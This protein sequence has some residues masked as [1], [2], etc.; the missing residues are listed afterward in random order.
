MDLS[1]YLLQYLRTALWSTTDDDGNPLDR[2]YDI[3]DF[4][5]DS[6]KVAQSELD[7]FLDLALPLIPEDSPFTWEDLTHDFWL[8]RNR[9]GA[10]FWDGE[11]PEPLSTQLT[12][13]SHQF[14]EITVYVGDDG[15]LYF[16]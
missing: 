6:I 1:T 13:I 14:S 12:N 4:S 7:K 5:I 3:S 15:K 11:Y 16:S 9:H 10:G 8:T 2:S